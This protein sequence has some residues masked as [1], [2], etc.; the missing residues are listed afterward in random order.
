MFPSRSDQQPRQPYVYNGNTAPPPVDGDDE[1][2]RRMSPHGYGYRNMPEGALSVTNGLP[3]FQP[4]H[5]LGDGYYPYGHHDPLERMP[6]SYDDSSTRQHESR[7]YNDAPE[8]SPDYAL[9]SEEHYPHSRGVIQTKPKHSDYHELPPPSYLLSSY[10]PQVG[11]FDGQHTPSRP[12]FP[13]ESDCSEGHINPSDV[14]PQLMLPTSTLLPRSEPSQACTPLAPERPRKRQRSTSDGERLPPQESH[15]RQHSDYG[16]QIHPRQ[17]HFRGIEGCIDV[18]APPRQAQQHEGPTYVSINS[19]ECYHSGNLPFLQ[20]RF[21]H[22]HWEGERGGLPSSCATKLRQD[23][24]RP[25]D[26]ADPVRRAAYPDAFVKELRRA[27]RCNAR[28]L[29]TDDT[30]DIFEMTEK[31]RREERCG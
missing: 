17:C 28:C 8:H 7:G 22:Q 5:Q 1:Y 19:G 25:L 27:I 29:D 12:I 24:S 30:G 23:V 16:D 4:P 26:C 10:P 3:S 13:R 20:H 6:N 9:P 2:P 15:Q 11:N 21:E 18:S 14:S 31:E